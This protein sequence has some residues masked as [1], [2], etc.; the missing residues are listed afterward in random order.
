[1]WVIIMNQSKRKLK[2]YQKTVGLSYKSIRK[3]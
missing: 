3:E 1:M 2:K